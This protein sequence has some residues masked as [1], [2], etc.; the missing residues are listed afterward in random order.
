MNDEVKIGSRTSMGSAPFIVGVTG[1][2]DLHPHELPLLRAA[3]SDF[4]HKFKARLPDTELRVAG[5]MAEGADLLVAET[6]VDL[7]FGVNA[8]LPMPLEQYAADFEPDALESV[9]ALLRHPLVDCVELLP[10]SGREGA[11]GML[12]MPKQ[13]D[14]TYA[15]LTEM[16]IQRTSLLLALWDGQSSPLPGGTA[17]TVL[18]YLGLRTKQDTHASNVVFVDEPTHVDS[19]AQPVFWIPAGRTSG[20]DTAAELGQ[21]CFLSGIGDNGLLMRQAMPAELAHQ[22]TELNEYNREFHRLTM[23]GGVKRLDSLM[24]TL[25]TDLPLHGRAT[26][27]QIDAEYGRADL[28]AVHYQR[29]SDRLFGFFSLTTFVMAI[30]YISYERLS[31]NQLLLYTYLLFL[32]S[33]LGLYFLLHGRR[34]FAKHLMYRVL[35]ETMRAKFFLRLSGAD[36]LVDAQ[37]VLSLSGIDRFHGFGWIS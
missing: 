7:G 6:A 27:A 31:E 35:A 26:L 13:R 17:D 9:K 32:L 30:T 23:R 37:E 2:R 19:D 20:D 21:P 8:M 11:T 4:L 14:A 28:L 15:N 5:G 1:H 10:T 25:P 33:G 36:H 16:L 12:R 29:R 34:W 24:A 3:V 22:L 18:R